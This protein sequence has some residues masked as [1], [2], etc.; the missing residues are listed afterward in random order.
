MEEKV[1]CICRLRPGHHCMNAVIVVAIVLWEGVAAPFADALYD[2]YI[3][4]VPYQAEETERRCGF[5]EG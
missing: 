2:Y 5:N 1:L 4:T 3:K